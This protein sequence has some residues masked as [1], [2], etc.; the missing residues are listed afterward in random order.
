MSVK[1]YHHHLCPEC[2]RPVKEEERFVGHYTRP[3]LLRLA[4]I[5]VGDQ[6]TLRIEDTGGTCKLYLRG[7]K[8]RTQ[9]WRVYENLKAALS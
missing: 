2:G 6:D 9:F 4:A 8:D 5:A 1:Y 7:F 3:D